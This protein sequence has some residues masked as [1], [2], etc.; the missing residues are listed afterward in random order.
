MGEL[1]RLFIVMLLAAI[2]V[3]ILLADFGVVPGAHLY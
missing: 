2:I 1:G 3:V